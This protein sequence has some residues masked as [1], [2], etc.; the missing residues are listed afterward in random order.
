LNRVTRTVLWILTVYFSLFVICLSSRII[1]FSL[2][3]IV[4]LFIVREFFYSS[5]KTHCIIVA[6]L[7]IVFT[8]VLHMNP[9]SRYRNIQE[10]TSTPFEIKAGQVQNNSIQIRLSLWWLAVKSINARNFMAG[11]GTGDVKDTMKLSARKYDIRNLLDSHDPHNQFL[12]TLLAHGIIGFLILILNFVMPVYYNW[13]QRDYLYLAFSFLCCSVCLT[14]SA[15][16]LQKGIV[17][18]A[19][20]GSLLLL[21]VKAFENFA[22]TGIKFKHVNV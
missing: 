10:V 5:D 12:F 4:L 18:F 16:E 15:L 17:F 13:I 2:G 1:I 19:L 8:L 6:T 9:V 20:I 14:E 7:T 11:T 22:V 21:R 3:F